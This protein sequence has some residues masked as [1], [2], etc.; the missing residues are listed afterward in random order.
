[1][2]QAI[3]R[4]AFTGQ[5]VPQDPNGEPAS[6]LLKRITAERERRRAL[7]SRPRRRLPTTKAI[8]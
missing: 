1:M 6:E 4:H 5:L 3:L 8:T 7:V 2:R